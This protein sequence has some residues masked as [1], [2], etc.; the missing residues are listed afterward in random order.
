MCGGVCVGGGALCWDLGV[1]DCQREREDMWG[2]SAGE[3]ERRGRGWGGQQCCCCCLMADA[4]CNGMQRGTGTQQHALASG[5][6][7]AQHQG[8]PAHRRSQQTL[9]QTEQADRQG[10]S[11]TEH[12]G[13]DRPPVT[14]GQNTQSCSLEWRACIA[15]PASQRSPVLSLPEKL[16]DHPV[17]LV[18]RPQH[19]LIESTS[20]AV[21]SPALCSPWHCARVAGRWLGA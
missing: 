16:A 19:D 4:H 9:Q 10:Q 14:A 11:G 12:G 5:W 3:L 6:R 2:V 20:S 8:R 7:Q 15:V 18:L 21:A 13:R 17:A 1:F